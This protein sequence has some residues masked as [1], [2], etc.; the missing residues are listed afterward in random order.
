MKN[1]IARIKGYDYKGLLLQHG[2]KIGMGLVGAIVIAVLAT[3]H[4]SGY[5]NSPD[6][7][8]KSAEKTDADLRANPFPAARVDEFKV[9]PA[10]VQQAKLIGPILASN[11]EL[12]TPFSPKLF[13]YRLPAEEPEVLPPVELYARSGVFSMEK[14][15][16]EPKY[17]ENGMP[18][19][20]PAAGGLA[21]MGL[22]P[23]V[24]TGAARGNRSRM[25]AAAAAALDPE[26]S[27]LAEGLEGANPGMQYASV[28]ESQMRRYNLVVGKIE[29][30]RQLEKLK[31]K[32]HLDSNYEAAYYLE[33]IPEFKIQR[34]KAM[35]G[36]KPWSDDES[37]WK[38]LN[39]EASVDLLLEAYN[40][41]PD[42][43]PAEYTNVAVTSPLPHRTDAMWSFDMA[44]HPSLPKLEEGYQYLEQAAN[45]AA[46]VM[47]EGAD[48][49]M[50]DQGPPAKGFAR[51]QVD[52]M[53]MRA[54]AMQIGG[55]QNY[56]DLTRQFLGGA[57]KGG[58]LPPH[59]A[60]MM[61]NSGGAMA[62]RGMPGGRAAPAPR[63]PSPRGAR[64]GAGMYGGGYGASMDM[65]E[66]MD[67]G[68]DFGMGMGGRMPSSMMLMNDPNAMNAMAMEADAL[69]FRYFDFDVEP[70]ECYRYRVKLVIYN[71]SFEM[72]FVASPDVAVGETRESQNWSVPSTPAA[73]ARDVEYGLFRVARKSRKIVSE[74]DVIQ[75]DPE[76][77]TLVSHRLAVAPGD[78]VGGI[79][80]TPRYVPAH[81]S[82]NR[83][84]VNFS[85][86]DLLVDQAPLP[87]LAS[88]VQ[89]DL[90]LT[91]Q[92]V[93]DIRD[94]GV[95]DQAVAI[96]RFGEM[97]PLDA[98]SKKTLGPARERYDA[99]KKEFDEMS[100]S[101]QQAGMGMDPTMG[102][103][104]MYSEM[105]SGMGVDPTMLQQGGANPMRKNKKLMKML[106]QQLGDSLGTGGRGAGG[107]GTGGRGR[108]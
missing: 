77:A 15:P 1:L 5:A 24:A 107:R 14:L 16:P 86:R 90:H 70:G 51:L 30:R 74:L 93:K 43:V 45:L 106:K 48:T 58:R 9:V 35:P 63:T 59:I 32:L 87:P 62:G 81:M 78:Y 4:W 92:E 88:S 41:D 96:S 40:F 25:A 10:E 61:E 94:K 29:R 33:Y 7:M 76:A 83:E 18:I 12:L 57:N 27:L 103:N 105:M 39:I 54:Q 17:D 37:S 101:M 69:L 31:Q 79:E 3:T 6:N 47:L 2:E 100:K 13:S 72:E 44:G 50:Y 80:E 21:G 26:N 8:R 55:E 98:D 64:G 91:N 46:G 68:A 53:Q 28:G 97:L 20:R 11:Y 85:S 34:Q 102:G 65:M 71:P 84:Y 66:M 104:E 73:V 42:V 22:N 95:L 38:D 60:A 23:A 108:N 99:Q 75:N 52:P 67:R 82:F 49:S 89:E 36:P 19:G 56:Q